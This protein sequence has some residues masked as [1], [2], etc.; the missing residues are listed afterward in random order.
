MK[1][2]R[3][4]SDTRKLGSFMINVSGLMKRDSE[5]VSKLARNRRGARFRIAKPEKKLYLV[6][7][8]T[9]ALFT[10]RPVIVSA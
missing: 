1:L 4:L 7:I 10:G 5:L 2:L 3:L 8:R 6:R 9:N